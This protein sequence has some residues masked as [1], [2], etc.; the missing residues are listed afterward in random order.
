VNTV[1]KAYWQSGTEALKNR[2]SGPVNRLMIYE[3]A[4]FY[5]FSRELI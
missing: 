1:G 5:V 4:E 2:D 3:I